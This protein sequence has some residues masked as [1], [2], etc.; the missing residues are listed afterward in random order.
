[1][2]VIRM[3]ADL[4]VDDVEA[5]K[6]FYAGYLGLSNAVHVAGRRDPGPAAE[7]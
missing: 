2:R 7:Q 3:M 5:A 6:G 1:M 4:K